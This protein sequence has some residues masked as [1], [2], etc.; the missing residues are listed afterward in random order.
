MSICPE[1]D[2]HSYCKNGVKVSFRTSLRYPCKKL[3]LTHVTNSGKN[4]LKALECILIDL[5]VM[6]VSGEEH[7]YGLKPKSKHESDI[8]M[9][10]SGR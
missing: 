8:E 9:P 2:Y 10:G 6:L 1:K 5:I 7:V 3:N 4:T